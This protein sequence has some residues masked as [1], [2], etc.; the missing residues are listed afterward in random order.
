MRLAALSALT[1]VACAPPNVARDGGRPDAGNATLLACEQT[2]GDPVVLP[3]VP[4]TV[5]GTIA[6]RT[7]RQAPNPAIDPSTYEGEQDYLLR[8][9][10]D[11]DPGPG[12]ARVLRQE[13]APMARAGT[14]RSLAYLAVM[15]DFQLT[16]DES[17]ARWA[18]T[19]GV[20][21]LTS[22]AMR[23][24]EAYLPIAVSAM[25]R[26]LARVADLSRPFDLGIVTGDCADMAQRNELR[27]VI[28]LMNGGRVHADSGEDDDPLPGPNNDPKDPFDAEPFPGPWLYVP[29]NHD[30]E[31]VG[32]FP[33]DA[34]NTA[35]ALGTRAVLG[36]RDYRLV[37]G[38]VTLGDVPADPERVPVSRD[39]IVRELVAAGGTPP[40]HGYSAASDLSLGAHYVYDAVPGLLRLI[41]LDTNDATGGSEGML[42][43]A[44]MQSFLLP[45]IEAAE[46]DGVL[47]MLASHHAT[48][49][50]DRRH[51]QFLA[52]V[53][54]A[55][56]PDEIERTLA[57]HPVVIAWLVG[58]S[59]RN[60]V[61]P[62][63]P[64]GA[65]GPGYWEIMTSALAD[66]PLQAR[67]IEVVDDGNDQLS[68]YATAIDFDADTCMER[69]FRRLALMDYASGWAGEHDEGPG[70]ANVRLI[71]PVPFEARARV[72]SAAAAARIE[73]DTTL[74]A[75]LSGR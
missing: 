72:A 7:A 49:S 64:A 28:A 48:S 36:A 25:N 71:V 61:R 45:A 43:R 55:I 70:D 39:D 10:G 65:S 22:A 47:V 16:D 26:T 27:W 50:I 53:A 32:I 75:G 23:P 59:H 67:A 15:S 69:R 73:S 5:A 11:L 52:E 41:V 46:R 21:D 17:P 1:L 29:G 51:G 2:E 34:Q 54:D 68:I 4:S 40:G 19:D 20:D 44:Q 14:R 42:L 74:E 60:R 38:E 37:W 9:F 33:P 8:G 30:V 56:A 6:P 12:R 13:L 24:Q 3:R 66:W 31:L 35:T 18:S 63:R 58:H 62:V 57:E